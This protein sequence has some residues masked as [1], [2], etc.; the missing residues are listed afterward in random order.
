MAWTHRVDD[1]AFPSSSYAEEHRKAAQR[2]EEEREALRQREL[3]AQSSP[4]NDPQVR[5]TTWERLHALSLPRSPDHP[6]VRLISRQTGLNVSQVRD[7]Q[8]R[9]ATLV[10]R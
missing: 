3:A 2:A 4:Q 8:V 6:L 10:P 9:R 7:E 5:I 1:V